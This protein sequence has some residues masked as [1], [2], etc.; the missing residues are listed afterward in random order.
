MRRTIMSALFLL[1]ACETVPGGMPA[2]SEAALFPSYPAH[3]YA[4]LEEGCSDQATVTRNQHMI[5]CEGVADVETTAAIIGQFDGTIDR[6]PTLVTQVSGRDT[7]GGYLVVADNFLR[8]PQ[9]NGNVNNVRFDDPE[10][11]AEMRDFMVAAG[12]TPVATQQST[13]TL[14]K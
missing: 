4:A 13:L 7:D 5:R 1:A 9:R 2:G 3:V 10:L 6:L 8:V 14:S 11:R 12:G